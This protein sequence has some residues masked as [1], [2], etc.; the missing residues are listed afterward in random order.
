M[1]DKHEY[2]LSAAIEAM[3]RVYRLDGKLDQIRVIQSWPK[4]VGPMISKHTLQVNIEKKIMFVQL[5]S[6]VL[7]NELNY[8]KSL[9]IKN[10]NKEA[11]SEVI[12]EIHFR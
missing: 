6:D 5:D 8:S 1:S 12:T 4:V 7:R 11:G 3:L 10:I 2:P 9:I